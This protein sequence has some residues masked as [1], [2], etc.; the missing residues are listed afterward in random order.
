MLRNAW[1]ALMVLGLGTF[2][3]HGAPPPYDPAVQ[4]VMAIATGDALFDR[5]AFP[6]ALAAYDTVPATETRYFG[7]ARFKGAW[8]L[9][10]LSR[11]DEAL[12]RFVAL[13]RAGLAPNARD[14]ERQMGREALTDSVR[15]FVRA[16]KPADAYRFYA[17][18][19]P[20]RR[21]ELAERVAEHLLEESRARDADVILV[22][23]ATALATEPALAV[24]RPRAVRYARLR[25]Q[26]AWQTWAPGDLRAAA[27]ALLPAWTLARAALGTPPASELEA[28]HGLLLR[29]VHGILDQLA[30]EAAKTRAPAAPDAPFNVLRA[31]YLA[32]FPS[33]AATLP[34]L[35]TR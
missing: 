32:V 21:L 19:A 6:D 4:A 26:G 1:F 18:L 8:C 25:L 28:E 5:Q 23:L 15:A 2:A 29:Q 34:H 27:A 35:P 7:Y 24:D 31:A 14:D 30:A 12:A 9:F 11:F 33:D 3:A 20:E 17:E 13:A 22:A 10:N 16:G